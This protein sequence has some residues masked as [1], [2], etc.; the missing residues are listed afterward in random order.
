MF[1]FKDFQWVWGF[2]FEEIVCLSFSLL[3]VSEFYG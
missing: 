3:Y 2:F 1:A